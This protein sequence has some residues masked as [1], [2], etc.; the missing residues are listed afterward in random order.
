MPFVAMIKQVDG[1]EFERVEIEHY[2]S[3]RFTFL[4]CDIRCPACDAPMHIRHSPLG[5]AYF[6][7]NPDPTG[8]CDYAEKEAETP[9][10]RAS[11]KMIIKTLSDDPFYR[12]AEFWE[13]YA[14]QTEHRKR[15]ADVF[16][17]HVD[18]AIEVHEAQLAGITDTTL[19]ERTFDYLTV[20]NVQTV[21]WWLGNDADINNN[22][23][24]CRDNCGQV[25]FIETERESV[26]EDYGPVMYRD[27]FRRDGKL[28]GANGSN[29]AAGQ[30]HN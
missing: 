12:G 10:H 25:A 7:H 20:E 27:S 13:E 29:G 5:L 30:N 16:V 6:Q 22:R 1:D 28:Y 18:G 9:E 19:S 17:R 21:L 26:R 11:K 23:N 8:S 14:L 4:G 3:P 15:V 24:W 2:E